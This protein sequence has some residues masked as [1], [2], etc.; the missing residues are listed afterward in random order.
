MNKLLCIK[1]KHKQILSLLVVQGIHWC[2]H[3]IYSA[4]FNLIAHRSCGLSWIIELFCHTCTGN[5]MLKRAMGFHDDRTKWRLKSEALL[6]TGIYIYK[7]KLFVRFL[8]R[9]IRPCPFVIANLIG[10]P[11]AMFLFSI[12]LDGIVKA[13]NSLCS[14]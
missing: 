13:S 10:Y 12:G 14:L 1:F 9:I 11:R 8:R 6:H 4:G 2:K 3:V 5:V 7:R